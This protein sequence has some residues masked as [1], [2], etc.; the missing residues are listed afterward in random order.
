L[1]YLAVENQKIQESQIVELKAEISRLASSRDSA[2][3]EHQRQFESLNSQYQANL[4]DQISQFD[5]VKND[6]AKLQQQNRL[7]RKVIT[8]MKRKLSRSQDEVTLVEKERIK[9]S[10]EISSIQLENS[11][12]KESFSEELN[13]SR[14]STEQTAET[15][16]KLK[17]SI[18]SLGS[19]NRQLTKKNA[20]L[21]TENSRLESQLSEQVESKTRDKRLS[22]VQIRAAQA[23]AEAK[24]RA[25]VAD[26]KLQCDHE[27]R[28]ILGMFADE[29]R[30]FVDPSE[31]ID[32]ASFER[33]LRRTHN[34]MNK[35]TEELAA[36]RRL[37]NASPSQTT[38][39]AVADLVCA[40]RP[41]V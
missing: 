14:L 12:L 9:L 18:L 11:R 21:Q 23:D 7:L 41:H 36:V 30:S 33:L 13:N 32:V 26:V 3:Q 10:S 20:L 40:V 6:R 2:V 19:K 37:V 31:R 17:E 35:M 34:E 25:A 15:I 24:I 39:N 22:E 4:S 5:Q 16:S 8:S 28:K 29:F 38:R 27:K 1:I